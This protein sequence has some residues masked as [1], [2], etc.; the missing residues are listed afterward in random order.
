MVRFL[1][2]LVALTACGGGG[3]TNTNE[4]PG[5]P[6]TCDVLAD[7][8]FCWAA[9]VDEAYACIPEADSS[10]TFDATRSTCTLG[11]GITVVFDEPVPEDPFADSADDY[12]W[13][14]TI[15]DGGGDCARF[16]DGDTGY[17]LTTNS[18]QAST[19]PYGFAGST[20]ECPNGDEYTAE[21]LFDLFECEGAVLPGYGYSGNV[22]WQLLGGPDGRF[23]LFECT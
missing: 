6:L 15:R 13:S 19:R 1:P 22:S 21:N 2:A 5:E 3:D 20:L 4:P 7:P 9:S 16:V 10:G 14:F 17:S 8:D 18:G 11:N 23:F 12:L